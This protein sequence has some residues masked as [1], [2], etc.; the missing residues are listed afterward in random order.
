MQ[1]RSEQRYD[2]G[3]PSSL[4]NIARQS[5]APTD[6]SCYVKVEM[7]GNYHATNPLVLSARAADAD[8]LLFIVLLVV[9]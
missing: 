2:P 3:N 8:Y 5:T 1:R 4:T 9:V 7:K 6:D